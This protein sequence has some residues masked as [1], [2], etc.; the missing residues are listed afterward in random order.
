MSAK[1]TTPAWCNRWRDYG[2]GWMEPC[3]NLCIIKYI[4]ML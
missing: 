2:G 4:I 3:G 1:R